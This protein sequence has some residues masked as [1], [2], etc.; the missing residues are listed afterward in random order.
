MHFRP[1]DELLARAYQVTLLGGAANVLDWDQQTYMPLKA[2]LTRAD[3]LALVRGLIHRR[4]T[5]APIGELL[6]AC[7]DHGFEPGSDEAANVREWRRDYDRRVRLP[8][9]LVEEFERTS[10]LARVAWAEAREKSEY[11]IFQPYL[12]KI[13]QLTR[14][15]A[16]HWGYEDSV[17]DA[18]MEEYEP[19]IRTSEI[20]KLFAQLRPSVIELF[21]QAKASDFTRKSLAGHYPIAGQKALNQAV[22]EALG[23]DLQAGRI[24]ATLHPFS[25][26]LGTADCRITTRYDE[27]DFTVSLYALLHEIG[28]GLY[29]QGL[30]AENY[31][32]PVGETASL[33]IHESQSRLWENK[34]GR[35]LAF[36][37]NWFPIAMNYLPEVARLSP[38]LITRAVNHVA[39][40]FIR[41]EADE[42]TYDLH[43]ILRFDLELQLFESQLD[44]ADVPAAWNE[45][46]EKL[47]GVPVPHDR[48]GCLQDIHWSL[49]SFG[50]FP[51]YTLGN[52]NS[53][54]IFARARQECP[55][56]DHQ[57]GKGSYRPLLHWLRQKIHV[58]GRRYLSQDLMKFATGESTQIHY[59]MEHLRQKVLNPLL[60]PDTTAAIKANEKE[61]YV[62]S[63]PEPARAG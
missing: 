8:Q 3:Q 48:F 39:P 61:S 62:R 15:K 32:T 52:L 58:Q 46:F 43:I 54:Q 5:A 49:G 19:G 6:K 21:K 41:L 34:V 4:A 12:E 11:V 36:W 44:A 59:Q 17:Y 23:Y 30:V 50:Y 9:K 24:D 14:E 13:L 7:E 29:E 40:S 35:T 51:T 28:H 25:L 18:L 45:E 22:A 57:L 47:F 2:A 10:T 26:N 16:E 42:V 27:T 20:K 63:T 31:G 33:G 1:Y 37:E 53:A 56:L 38:E 60:E 55:E